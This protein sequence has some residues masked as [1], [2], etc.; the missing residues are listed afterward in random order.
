[1]VGKLYSLDRAMSMM[2]SRCHVTT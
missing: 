2:T 1:M